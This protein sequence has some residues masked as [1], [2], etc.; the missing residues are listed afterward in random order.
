MKT[1]IIILLSALSIC[2]QG[3]SIK[4]SEY[5]AAKGHESK[6][7]YFLGFGEKLIAAY[8]PNPNEVT[9][10][11][12]DVELHRKRN[13]ITLTPLQDTTIVTYT[14]PNAQG[15]LKITERQI[16][17]DKTVTTV[18]DITVQEVNKELERIQQDIDMQ[19][20]EE[21]FLLERIEYLRVRVQENRRAIRL[22]QR[23]LLQAQNALK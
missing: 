20:Q 4:T 14:K 12:V 19:A 13:V 11:G 1:L 10:E 18:R 16:Y 6:S 15:V 9:F 23:K 21:K 5:I 17:A 8:E 2:A 7:V 3:Y 22:S